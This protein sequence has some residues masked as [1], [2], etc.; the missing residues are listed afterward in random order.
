MDQRQPRG[1]RSGHERLDLY[2]RQLQTLGYRCFDSDL[3]IKPPAQN[4]RLYV[5]I[6]ASR[7]LRGDDCW[8]K[9]TARDPRG[10]MKLF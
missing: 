4:T 10:Q 8:K 3:T 6:L 5:L 9:A 1:Q 7:H 2:K